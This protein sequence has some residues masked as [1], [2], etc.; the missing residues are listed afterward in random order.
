MIF[1]TP[2]SARNF[3]EQSLKTYIIFFFSLN[4]LRGDWGKFLAVNGYFPL[5]GTVFLRLS[6][7]AKCNLVV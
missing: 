2:K 3:V 5:K 4:Q 1:F 6:S 7:F